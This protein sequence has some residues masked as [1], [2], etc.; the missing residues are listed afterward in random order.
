MRHYC[1]FVSGDCVCREDS[2]R[3]DVCDP[4]HSNSVHQY[5]KI[6][7]QCDTGSCVKKLH[8]GS[9]GLNYRAKNTNE[10]KLAIFGYSRLK[11]IGKLSAKIGIFWQLN[12]N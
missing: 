11:N 3:R 2:K 4:Q 5:P 8:L 10:K 1:W 9:S 6:D 7:S 12:S